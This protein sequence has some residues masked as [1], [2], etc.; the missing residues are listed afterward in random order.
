MEEFRFFT[1]LDSAHLTIRQPLAEDGAALAS[2]GLGLRVRA[3]ARFNASLL[4]SAPLVGEDSTLIDFG[5]RLR[6]QFRIWAEF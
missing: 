5:N 3:F 6:G 4:L 2:V 1:F